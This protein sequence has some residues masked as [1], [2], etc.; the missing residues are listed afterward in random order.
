MRSS[1]IIRK[2]HAFRC[3]PGRTVQV[4]IT[5]FCST[6]DCIWSRN[7]SKQWKAEL[8]HIDDSCK[9][10]FSSD[11]DTWKLQG[12]ERCCGT[13]ISHQESKRKESL[14]WEESG[15]VF[16][17]EGTWTMF[18]RRLMLFQSWQTSTR[19]LVRWSETKRTIV[20]SSTKFE[21]QDWRRGRKILKNIRQHRW[22]L[23]RQKERNSV[24]L[25]NL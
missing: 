18:K 25:H 13:R 10:S 24:P 19:R 17:V 14:R 7:G 4:K 22:K 1:S 9:T 3:D 12:L 6:P 15:R 21:G 11:D 23:F 8:S 2:R 5:E 16:S 20:L